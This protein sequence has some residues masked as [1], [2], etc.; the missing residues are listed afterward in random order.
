MTTFMLLVYFI[1]VIHFGNVQVCL[2]TRPLHV[3][4]MVYICK[5]IILS[6]WILLK[7]LYFNVLFPQMV[8][9]SWIKGVGGFKGSRFK[10]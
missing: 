7:I 9:I 8:M 3:T 4:L 2:N 10:L 5:G 6:L 1:L